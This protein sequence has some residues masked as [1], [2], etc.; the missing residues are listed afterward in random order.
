[1]KTDPRV[2]TT[3]AYAEQAANLI[4]CY[5]SIFFKKSHKDELHLLPTR[6]SRVLD[7]GAGSG[8]DAAWFAAQEIG[9]SRL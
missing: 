7:V 5:E 3:Q 6:P 8:R 2:Q 4:A 9:C 1:L